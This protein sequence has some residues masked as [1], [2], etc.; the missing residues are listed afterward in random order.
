MI[1]KLLQKKAEEFPNKVAL[2][3]PGKKDMN[4]FELNQ[5]IVELR[6]IFASLGLKRGDRVAMVM[7]NG[8]PMIT[9]GLSLMSFASLA[10]LNPK[11]KKHEFDF[12]LSDLK[13]KAL[14]VSRGQDSPAREVARSLG[15]SI[16]EIDENNLSIFG[17]KENFSEEIILAEE[18]DI[19][20]VLHTSGTTS[21]PKIVPLTQKN[22]SISAQ[23]T[24]KTLQ[25]DSSDKC[26][27]VMP[28][29][30]IHGLVVSLATLISGGTLIRPE[31]FVADEF[32]SWLD[33][34][35]PT[36]YTA[37]PTIHQAIIKE[38][39]K[40]NL[41]NIKLKKIRS[42]SAP[43]SKEIIGSLENIFSAPVLESY[44]MTEAAL[45]ITSNQMS[46]G[47]RK[48]GSAGKADG[49][50]LKVVNE[51]GE[52]V[53]TGEVGEVL[54]K[55]EN[56][57]NAYENNP[58]ANE[59]SFQDGWFRTGDL[60]YLDEDGYLFITGRL[61]EMINKGGEKISPREIDEVMMQHEAVYQALSFSVP[62]T[63]LGE[64]VGVAII[65]ESGF[66]ITSVEL[67]KFVREKLADFKVPQVVV[68]VSEIPKGPTGKLQR[69]GLYEKLK[70]MNL[71]KNIEETSSLGSP[72]EDLMLKIWQEVLEQENFSMDDNFFEWGGDSLRAQALVDMIK[73]NGYEIEIDDIFNCPNVRTLLAQINS[74]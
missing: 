11:Y 37:A 74:K 34:Y 38:A 10:P 25:L 45:Q 49:P 27:N 54:I 51:S 13:P 19:A 2:Q 35:Q 31:N 4:F 72:S 43:L 69:I 65:L 1:Y 15:I 20:L 5:K 42:S 73:K 29:F 59:E 17:E 62:H 47:K 61:K 57:I 8:I 48:P 40:N 6:K 53:A 32:F 33:K 44:G 56:V 28:L 7:P 22:I 68:F 58:L 26:L 50:Y 67:Q 63:S 16:L 9:V 18:N 70:D 14:L 36:W 66:N 46:P 60:G 12:Y 52:E 24:V 71:I 21:R 23:N 41:E 3:S 64:E 55:G 39:Q 30:H